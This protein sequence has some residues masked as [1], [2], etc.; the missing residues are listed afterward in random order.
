MWHP[1]IKSE[2]ARRGRERAAAWLQE[3]EAA[4]AWAPAEALDPS[5]DEDEASLLQALALTD[6]TFLPL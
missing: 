3:A 4:L 2:A 1:S 6:P 5:E